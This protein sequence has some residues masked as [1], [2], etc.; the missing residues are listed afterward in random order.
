VH[1][2]HD[3]RIGDFVVTAPMV[4]GHES[5][6]IV[7]SLGSSATNLQLGDRVAIE[8]GIPCRRCERCKDGHYNLCP[9]MVF[10]A[11]PPYDG[12]LCRYYRVPAD[13]CYKLP[14]HVSL[15]EGALV[16]PTS[17]GVHIVRQANVL[18]GQSVVV[19]GAG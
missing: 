11:T 17:V 12:T 19:F 1:Y 4:L 14:E 13:F 5:A 2:W 18:P 7:H 9:A 16:E 15:E 3:G 8:P 10:A 6:G